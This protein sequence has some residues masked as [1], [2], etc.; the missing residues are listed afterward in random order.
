LLANLWARGT[1]LQ[2][3]YLQESIDCL[4][5][6][7][8]GSIE[9]EARF[10]PQLLR[11]LV[12]QVKNKI[13]GDVKARREMRPMGVPRD[14]TLPQPYLSL[15]LEL[16][17]ESRYQATGS[18]ITVEI[19]SG[20]QATY[21]T[22]VDA[23]NKTHDKVEGLEESLKNLKGKERTKELKDDL[24]QARQNMKTSREALESFN[25]YVIS[26]RGLSEYGVLER[27]NI[28]VEFATLLRAMN[29][30]GGLKGGDLIEEMQPTQKLKGG[31]VHWMRKYVKEN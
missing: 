2:C 6:T 18:A 22:L 12:I 23:W 21:G 30:G 3:A 7:Y 24:K 31:Y 25:R 15:V 8:H 28:K 20:D 11:G 29:S 14:K 27:A 1:A 19:G 13:A 4:F 16:G 26:V 10:D 9:P 5:A 17:T